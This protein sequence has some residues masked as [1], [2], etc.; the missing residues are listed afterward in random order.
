MA[1]RF[2]S[3]GVYASALLIFMA[4]LGLLGDV[5]LLGF[6]N[7]SWDFI[8]QNPLDSGRQG[9]IASIL[10]STAFILFIAMGVAVPLGLAV[11]VWLAEFSPKTSRFAG[12]TGIS[13]DVLAGVPSIVYGLFGNAF[14]CV[15]LGLGFSIVSGGLTLAC[16]VLPVFVRTCEIGI[17]SVRNDWRHGADALGLWLG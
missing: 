9:G 5:V 11:A 16:M 7:L 14:F 12:Y 10:V 6:A 4:L 17:R 3:L 13:L 15:Y 2:L 1:D 8:V